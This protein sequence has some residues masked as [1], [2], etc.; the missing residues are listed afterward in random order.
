MNERASGFL[1]LKKCQFPLHV[2]PSKVTKASVK[3]H[4]VAA[5][6]ALGTGE[7]SAMGGLELCWLEHA[8]KQL[9]RRAG[10]ARAGCAAN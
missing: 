4:E 6:G 5:D 9:P 2:Q 7:P 1:D 8:L 3:R 10:W